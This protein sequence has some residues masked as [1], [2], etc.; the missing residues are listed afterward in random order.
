MKRDTKLFPFIQEYFIYVIVILEKNITRG[1]SLNAIS[2]RPAHDDRAHSCLPSSKQADEFTKTAKQSEP[3]K[4]FGVGV[5][6]FDKEKSFA[7]MS[8]TS[9]SFS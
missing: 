8:G 2:S 7:N 1:G 6:H 3:H 9:H 5:L 4:Y